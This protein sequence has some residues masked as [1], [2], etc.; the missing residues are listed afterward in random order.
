MILNYRNFLIGLFTTLLFSCGGSSTTETSETETIAE[1]TTEVSAP[2]VNGSEI[3]YSVDTLEMKGYIAYD[4]NST[5]KRPGVLVIHEWWGHNDY[6]RKRADMLAEMGYVALAVDMYGDGKQAG[7]PEDAGKFAMS[8][9][10]NIDAAKARF[11]KAV[12]TLKNNPNVDADK[13]AAIGYCFG[14]SVALTMANSGMDLDGVAAF[15]SGLQL[16]VPP[17]Q[18]KLTAKVLVCNGAADPFVPAEQV[19]AFKAQMDEAGADYK[20]IGYEGALHGFT[21]PDATAMGEKFELPLKYDAK[22][23]EQSWNELKNFFAGIF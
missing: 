1:E 10:G 5:E 20:Y 4:E 16:P 17:E 6:A 8:V 18:G 3:S 2:K 13:I 12:E 21:N 14:G 22:V 11:E 15:H 7:H 19:D 9:M 23:D